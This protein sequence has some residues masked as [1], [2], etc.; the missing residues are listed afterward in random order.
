MFLCI[1]KSAFLTRGIILIA[2]DTPLTPLLAITIAESIIAVFAKLLFHLRPAVL[3]RYSYCLVQ[4]TNYLFRQVFDL[5]AKP[6]LIFV[7]LWSQRR[8][9]RCSPAP[10]AVASFKRETQKLTG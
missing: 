2:A 1:Q 6:K 9:L 3:G 8:L 5:T 7:L 4:P 10:G